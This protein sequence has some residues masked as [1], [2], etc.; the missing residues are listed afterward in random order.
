VRQSGLRF[1]LVFVN[2]DIGLQMAQLSFL[3]KAA[4]KA[5]PLQR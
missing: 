3:Q 5:V 1:T 2:P 4:N